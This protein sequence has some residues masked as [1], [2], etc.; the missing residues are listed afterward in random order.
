MPK[1]DEDDQHCKQIELAHAFQCRV[2]GDC[3]ESAH[4]FSR[5]TIL[6]VSQRPAYTTVR[7]LLHSTLPQPIA[8]EAQDH[9]IID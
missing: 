9:I 4:L 7:Q 1:V 3:G 5:L 6:Q 8:E 2:C